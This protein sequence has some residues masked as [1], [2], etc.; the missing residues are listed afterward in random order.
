MG[1]KQKDLASA[2]GVSEAAVSYR[3]NGKSSIDIELIPTESLKNDRAERSAVI[4]PPYA[5]VLLGV[6]SERDVWLTDDG[7]GNVA[8]PVTASVAF[9]RW[10]QGQPFRAVPWRNLRNSYVTMMHASGYDLDLIAKL[11][12]HSTNA[13][14]YA[15]YD[16]PD[17]S[18]L[19]S[20]LSVEKSVFIGWKTDSG[21]PRYLK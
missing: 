18:A 14:T 12:G 9:S 4:M 6:E 3:I 1:A 11:C 5:S 16:R 17:A 7:L 10:F 19:V 8:S 15:R 2:C 13:T 20:A 21:A